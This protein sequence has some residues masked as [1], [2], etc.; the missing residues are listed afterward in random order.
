LRVVKA[1]TIADVARHL[2]S[3]ALLHS[4]FI[5]YSSRDEEFVTKFYTDLQQHGA[6]CWYAREDLKIGDEF[7]SQIDRSILRYDKLLLVLSKNSL[8]SPW[9]AKEVE[10]AFERE[11]D[12]RR[13]VLFPIRLDDTVMD[14]KIGWAADIRRK[15]HIG[16][17]RNWRD[18]A[19]Y[20]KAFSRLLRDL[21]T[22]VSLV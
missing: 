7:R 6:R 3:S 18:A 14:V 17:F 2:E 1:R 20:D 4:C 22:D 8:E 11:N 5:S 15:K 13:N 19:Q 16:D 12:E 10:T 21:S 9:V